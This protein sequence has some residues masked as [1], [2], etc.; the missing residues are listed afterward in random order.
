MMGPIRVAGK[1]Y[2]PPS[3]MP[4]LKQ[5]PDLS[6]TDLADIATFTRH[7]WGNNKDAVKAATVSEV[8]KELADRDTVF[9]SGELEKAYP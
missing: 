4:G 7:A 2:N 1:D 8:R 5:N 6:D 3:V 9:T